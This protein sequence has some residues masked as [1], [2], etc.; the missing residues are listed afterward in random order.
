[1]KTF[2]VL[3]LFVMYT[4]EYFTDI[5]RKR[6]EEEEEKNGENGPLFCKHIHVKIRIDNTRVVVVIRSFDERW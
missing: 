4:N 5:Y 1:M 6:G 2:R 3:F